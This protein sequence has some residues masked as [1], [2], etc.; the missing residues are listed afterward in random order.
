[1]PSH[2]PSRPIKPSPACAPS[3]HPPNTHRIR[4]PLSSSPPSQQA[5]PG[6]AEAQPGTVGS[7]LAL[8]DGSAVVGVVGGWALAAQGLAPRWTLRRDHQ[9][10]ST[11]GVLGRQGGAPLREPFRE[12]GPLLLLD[13]ASLTP[14]TAQT[15]PGHIEFPMISAGVPAQV[16]FWRLPLAA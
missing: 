15:W 7:S 10:G 6:R 5:G 14:A 9:R 1:M 11:R 12:R 16:P 2:L 13:A 3:I 4:R 8:M